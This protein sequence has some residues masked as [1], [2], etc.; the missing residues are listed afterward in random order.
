M[1]KVSSKD[2]Q[3]LGSVKDGSKV[4]AK[5]SQSI[6]SVK[7]MS[8][9]V[10]GN[11]SGISSKNIPKTSNDNSMDDFLE[12]ITLMKE[13]TEKRKQLMVRKIKTTKHQLPAEVKSVLNPQTVR[14]LRSEVNSVIKSADDLS[15]H[16]DQLHI[17]LCDSQKKVME[18]KKSG[19]LLIKVCSQEKGCLE[20][21]KTILTDVSP[22]EIAQNIDAMRRSKE[23]VSQAFLDSFKKTAELQSFVR[24]QDKF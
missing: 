9:S 15:K 2:S 22:E 8:I 14:N 4:S 11:K 20:L 12:S 1:S 13:I 10:K 19:N 23:V 7:D 3:S 5:G 18:S 21:F 17:F 16:E 24:E 6:A